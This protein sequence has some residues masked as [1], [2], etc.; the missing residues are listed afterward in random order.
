MK[1][2]TQALAPLGYTS[3]IVSLQWSIGQTIP[4]LFVIYAHNPQL[5]RPRGCHT[6]ARRGRSEAQTPRL[7]GLLG[8]PTRALV[9]ASHPTVTPWKS[10][11]V[12]EHR[13]AR[14]RRSGVSPSPT[15]AIA[16][17]PRS[18]TRLKGYEESTWRTAA[19]R[20]RRTHAAR[21]HGTGRNNGVRQTSGDE[22]PRVE[23]SRSGRRRPPR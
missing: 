1:N 17:R 5:G 13:N 6:T 19:V 18:A 7:I 12:L 8:Q 9:Q 3:H 15:G 23:Q 14:N 11:R 21:T 16:I 10:R 4:K 2:Q 22:T 20:R